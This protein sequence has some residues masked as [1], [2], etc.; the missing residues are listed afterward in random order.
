MSRHHA[1]L[2]DEWRTAA[3]ESRK[4]RARL[5]RILDAHLQGKGPAPEPRMIEH[6]RH[7]QDLERAKLDAAMEYAKETAAGP[8][9]GFGGR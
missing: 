8:P 6:V 4:A 7:L 1:E 5:S 2:V 9:T 3:E